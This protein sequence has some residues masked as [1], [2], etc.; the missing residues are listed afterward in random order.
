M[1]GDEIELEGRDPVCP[2]SSKQVLQCYYLAACM[3][4]NAVNCTDASTATIS[5]ILNCKKKKNHQSKYI[6]CWT[7]ETKHNEVPYFRDQQN[8]LSPTDFCQSAQ[9][10]IQRDVQ[11]TMIQCILIPVWMSA[12][13][14]L[15]G[16]AR[17]SV[18]R[19]DAF[20]ISLRGPYPTHFCQFSSSC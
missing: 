16:I 18:T 3:T 20:L 12:C 17:Y 5:L 15:H 10:L 9:Q 1:T 11:S 14:S 6:K 4:M 2:V 7:R 19:D 8:H 13:L